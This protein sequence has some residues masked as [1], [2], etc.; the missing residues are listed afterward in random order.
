MFDNSL[1]SKA[2]ILSLPADK[3]RA[4][5]AAVDAMANHLKLNA[6]DIFKAVMDREKIMSTGM[7]HGVAIPHAKVKGLKNFSLSISRS[8]DP[9]DYGALDS[10]PVRILALLLSPE[11]Q[12]KEHVRM[13]AD[14]TKR[15]KFSHVRQAILDAKDT[16]GVESAFLQAK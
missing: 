3:G 13:I 7:G 9:I 4:I 8:A 11:D 5:R 15:L 10:T 2:T 12:V 14:I 1:I 16:A 6:E